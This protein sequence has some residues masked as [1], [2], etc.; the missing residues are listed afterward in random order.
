M[1]IPAGFASRLARMGVARVHL[2]YF[3]HEDE[4]RYE[5]QAKGS[6]GQAVTLTPGLQREVEE[7]VANADLP[8]DGAYLWDL[9]TGVITPFGGVGYLEGDAELGTYVVSFDGD[10]AA[11]MD[12]AVAKAPTTAQV[13]AWISHPDVSVR[14]A[15][16]ANRAI[17]DSWLSPL[18]GDLD[19]DVVRLM[20]GRDGRGAVVQ[21]TRQAHDPLTLPRVLEALGHSDWATVRL[22]VAR[23]PSTPARLLRELAQAPQ[24][25]FPLAV[26]N[27]A[28][29]PPDLRGPLLETLGGITA[30]ETQHDIARRREAPWALLVRWLGS[31]D[32]FLRARIAEHANT[33]DDELKALSMDPDDTVRTAVRRRRRQQGRPTP[34]DPAWPPEEQWR[35]ARSGDNE[36]ALRALGEAPNLDP[37]VRTFLLAQPEGWTAVVHRP[38]VT[39]A[40]LLNLLN[41]RPVQLWRFNGRAELPPAVLRRLAEQHNP[42]GR[43]E[44]A[45]W[46]GLPHDLVLTLA[47]DPVPEVRRAIAEQQ[48]LT[49]DLAQTLADD[50]LPWVAECLLRNPTLP[51]AVA[52]SVLTRVGPGALNPYLHTQDPLPAPL[53]EVYSAFATGETLLALA[54]NPR[55]PSSPLVNELRALGHTALEV[56]IARPATPPATLARLVVSPHDQALIQHPNCTAAVLRELITQRVKR[57]S[58]W[59]SLGNEAQ[60]VPDLLSSPLLTS[61]LWD[62]LVRVENLQA[63]T[64]AQVAA[65]PDLPHFIALRL[66]EDPVGAVVDALRRN[67]AVRP[68]VRFG[69]AGP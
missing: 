4:T 24:W 14:R 40:D 1:S 52:R 59:N 36:E 11:V 47:H 13:Q 2:A 64:R 26:L 37:A 25:P 44:V 38:D 20:A 30:V 15:V 6:Q 53:L 23:N 62:L 49:P 16:A 33:P 46:P 29:C 51:P 43:A 48:G 3:W 35:V 56:L 60:L 28:S 65:H 58:F 7:A 12:A 10:E 45:G 54:H 41:A 67:P 17:P 21:A 66:A 19:N 32:P 61:D 9:D 34:Y 8:G 68:E 63:D 18:H 39:E 69:S 42:D 5:I 57:F 55:T 50:P 31:P 27:N 22:A